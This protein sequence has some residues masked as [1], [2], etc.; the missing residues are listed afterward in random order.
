MTSCECGCSGELYPC[1]TPKRLV[2]E[3]VT[4][5]EVEVDMEANKI[6][7][8]RD[9]AVFDL[10]DLGDAAPVIDAGGIFEYAR[11]EGMIATV[12]R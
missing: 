12:E 6:K 1:E 11:R 3:F 9:G 5:E 2:E 8:L 7:R 4:G 10:M